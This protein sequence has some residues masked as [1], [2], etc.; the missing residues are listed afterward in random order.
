MQL[1]NEFQKLTSVP[2]A[3]FQT[4]DPQL[5]TSMYVQMYLDFKRKSAAP[6][7]Q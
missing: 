1:V 5:G 7:I 2:L 6:H 3:A 4:K